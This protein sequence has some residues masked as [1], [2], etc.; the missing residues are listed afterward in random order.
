MKT[1]DSTLENDVLNRLLDPLA[2]CLTPAAARRIAQFRAN[3]ATQARI[4]DLAEKCNQGEMTSSERREYEA[5]VHAIDL[6][7]ILQAKARAKLAKTRK[8]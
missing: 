6:V 8:K 1:L 3:G 7:A 2:D 5:Y 4:A